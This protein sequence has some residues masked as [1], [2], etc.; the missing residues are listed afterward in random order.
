MV[1]RGKLAARAAAF[2]ASVYPA[3]E[4]RKGQAP[5]VCSLYGNFC[6]AVFLPCDGEDY[7]GLLHWRASLLEDV[8]AAADSYDSGVCGHEDMEQAEEQGAACGNPGGSGSSCGTVGKMC[9]RLR[10]TVPKG[11]EYS[12]AASGGM[13][14]M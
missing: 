13:L 4:G 12:E 1:Y 2:S 5:S 6:G 9:L 11:R 14:G 8:L 10:R 7:H 3:V